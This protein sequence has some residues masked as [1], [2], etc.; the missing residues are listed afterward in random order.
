MLA[1][2][3]EAPLQRQ[4]KISNQNSGE[5]KNL[6]SETRK[7]KRQDRNGLCSD[8]RVKI[9]KELQGISP[10]WQQ[11]SWIFGLESDISF[12][13]ESSGWNSHPDTCWQIQL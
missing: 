6:S 4:T 9:N 11:C 2:E 12:V 5:H 1:L 3:L 13:C 10:V 7:V 8:M